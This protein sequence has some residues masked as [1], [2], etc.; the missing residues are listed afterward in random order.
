MADAIPG[1]RFEVVP[2]A[3][4]LAAMEVPDEVNRLLAAH[5]GS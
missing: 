2:G 1:A 5:L 4:H 3:A